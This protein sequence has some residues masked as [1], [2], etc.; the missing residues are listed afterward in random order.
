MIPGGD[1]FDH[2]SPTSEEHHLSR[3][4]L[5]GCRGCTQ[6]RPGEGRW[7]DGHFVSC[8]TR[9]DAP[10]LIRSFMQDPNHPADRQTVGDV[11]QVIEALG[12]DFRLV[13]LLYSYIC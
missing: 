13:V 8:C 7:G 9:K 2:S 6:S 11:C 10:K 5:Q 12:G 3:R 4:A 1:A